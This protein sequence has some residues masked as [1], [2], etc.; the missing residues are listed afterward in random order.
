MGQGCVI[1]NEELFVSASIGITMYPDDGDD[2]DVLVRNADA[3]MY[4]AKEAGRSTYAFYTPEMN[5]RARARMAMENDLRRA[6]AKGEFILYYQP[7]VCCQSGRV[8]GL[9]ALLR[10]RH[11]ERGMV[12]PNEFVSL[13]E[14]TGLIIPVGEWVLRT[15]CAQTVAWRNR[16]FPELTVAV[17]LS[18]RQIESWDVLGGVAT[19]L[20]ETG[21]PASA[22]ELE[23]TETMLMEDEDAV[24]AILVAL[25]RKGVRVAVDDFGTG[26]SSLSYL[27]RFPID[28]LKV[29]RSFV[30]DI[31]AD[32]GDA[33]I[34]RAVIRMGHE[35]ALKVVAEGVETE[36][37][38]QLLVAAGCDQIQGYYIS[39]PLPAEQLECFLATHTGIAFPASRQDEWDAVSAE[40]RYQDVL[41]DLVATREKMVSLQQERDRLHT[42]CTAGWQ[43]W[44]EAM[45]ATGEPVISLARDGL[46]LYANPAA[47]RIFGAAGWLPGCVGEEVFPTALV[48]ALRADAQEEIQLAF[49]AQ[50]YRVSITA[51][52]HDAGQGSTLLRFSCLGQTC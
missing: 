31:T 14:E 46:I 23:L 41:R 28:S 2:S 15:A 47:E 9:E 45:N 27:K 7:K 32:S 51:L 42:Q 6:L 13:L 30:Q 39:R 19:A 4:L 43:L 29:D 52:D 20:G 10:W 12:G 1:E 44:S 24:V 35:L 36:G 21:L 40:E 34:T 5:A 8:L 16:G 11:P 18:A 3:A 26:Y 22:L 25:K 38:M 33:S 50:T 37:Q 17:N 48:T 49:G